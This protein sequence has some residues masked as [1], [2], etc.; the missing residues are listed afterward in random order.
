MSDI[1]I[2][3]A[4]D[5]GASSGRVIAAELG[6]TQIQLHDVHRFDNA[7]VLIGK[8]LH[9]DVIALWSNIERGLELAAKQYGPRIVSLGVDTWGVDY[10]LLD[11]NEDMV[12]P[13]FCYRDARTQGAMEKAFQRISRNEIFAES[14]IQ[15]MPIN[16][17]YQLYSMRLEHSPLLD[18]AE[19]FL[20]IP[21]FIHWLLTGIRTNEFTNASTTQFLNPNKGTWSTKILEALEIPT[22]LFQNPVQSG[23]SLGPVRSNIRARTGLSESVQVIVPATHD[24][25]SAV[26]AVPAEG[27]ALDKP[28]W[29]YISSGTWSLMGVE[30]ASPILTPECRDLNFTN[31]G[32]AHGSVR[33]LKNIAGLWPFQQCR[34]A[35]QRRGRDYHWDQLAQMAMYAPEHQCAIDLEHGMFVAPDDMLD[36]IDD[37][38]QRTGQAV[39]S[40]DAVIARATLE[41]LALR[42]RVCLGWL[43]ELLGYRLDTIHIVGGGVQNRLLC[44]MTAD[45]CQRPVIAGPIEA[46]ALGNVIM[47]SIALGKFENIEQ[48]RRWLLRMPGMEHYRPGNPGPWD[49]AALKLEQAQRSIPS[50]THAR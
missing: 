22:K 21:D 38:L 47:Q 24:T 32:G 15:F 48:G 50:D 35:W 17:L 39:P 31:E 46:T 19:H 29:C 33:L 23:T 2:A 7:P 41:S 10:V 40:S 37:Y 16:T 1:P 28:S 11:R 18:V 9:W 8:R 49:A 20:M 12:G 34:V 42:Y 6:E 25:G 36:A 4:I 14:G 43:E 44:Q 5:L 27:F 13:P 45:A 3:L 26:I 30:L